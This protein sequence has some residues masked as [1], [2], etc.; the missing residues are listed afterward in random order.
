MKGGRRSSLRGPILC[1]FMEMK[2]GVCLL[3]VCEIPGGEMLIAEG[4]EQ[5]IEA[6]SNVDH[7]IRCTGS[8]N[9]DSSLSTATGLYNGISCF[10]CFISSHKACLTNRS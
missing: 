3:L 6:E 7:K 5:E 8:L 10:M 4:E 2:L 9:S 1:H